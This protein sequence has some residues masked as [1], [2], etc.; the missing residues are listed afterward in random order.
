[1]S[2]DF[3]KLA[4]LRLRSKQIQED[5]VASLDYFAYDG[6]YQH[7]KGK[8]KISVSSTATCVLSLAATGSWKSTRAQTKALL[9][10]LISKK[11]SAGLKDN[12]PFTIAW[13]L[14]AVTALH[15][16]YDALEPATNV[17]VAEM[18]GI[19]QN[20]VKKGGVSIDT[21]PPTAYL[22]QLVVRAL[23][24]RSKLTEDLEAA[25]NLWAWG[26]LPYQIGLV[27]AKSKTGD[28]FAIAYLVML[29]T[30]VTPRSE[31]TPEQTSIQRGG[32]KTFFEC[33]RDDGT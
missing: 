14:E 17:R 3:S 9:E 7:Y 26:E 33:Q 10:N 27:Q 25:V 23:K 32:L 13:I 29:V 19:L 21:Y 15:G 11:N 4:Y 12:N 5:Q 31:T 20:A 30:A 1:M 28:P 18:E 8:N 16:L 6:G 2:L 24:R 22:T